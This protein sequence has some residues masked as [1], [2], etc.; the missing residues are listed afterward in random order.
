MVQALFLMWSGEELVRAEVLRVFSAGDHSAAAR[1]KLEQLWSCESM[2]T[3]RCTI[4]LCEGCKLIQSGGG[5]RAAC[6][7]LRQ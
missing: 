3:D 7:V 1:T 5:T 6:D 2:T 4:Y